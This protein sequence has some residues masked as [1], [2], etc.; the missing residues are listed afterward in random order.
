MQ[1]RGKPK[2]KS[3]TY[4]LIAALGQIEVKSKM[5]LGV[6]SRLAFL[7]GDKVYKLWG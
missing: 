7:L 4:N 6:G 5:P 1:T 3:V 2:A